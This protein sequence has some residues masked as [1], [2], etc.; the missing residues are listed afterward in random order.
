MPFLL[1]RMLGLDEVITAYLPEFSRKRITGKRLIRLTPD[2][3]Q[4]D[5]GM[6]KVGHQ[7]ILMEK[8]RQLQSQYW[9]FDNETLQS[10]LF[11]V[12]RLCASIR[13]AI[14]SLLYITGRQ[15]VDSD[16]VYPGILEDIQE[17][18]VHILNQTLLLM[19]AV[20]DAVFWLK[21]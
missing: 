18:M 9:S 12:S 2:E 1:F 4:T 15:D 17:A 16:G 13:S 10:V 6:G 14:K 19:S 21:R 5:Y 7:M 11:R 20:H 3:L 8:L